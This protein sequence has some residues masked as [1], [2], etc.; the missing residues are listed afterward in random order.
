MAKG[1]KIIS[2]LLQIMALVMIM[3]SFFIVE[4]VAYASESGVSQEETVTLQVKEGDDI[5]TALQQAVKQYSKV[6]IPAG[7]YTCSGVALTGC[8]N[9][10]I[11]ATGASVT[12]TGIADAG[13]DQGRT[14]TIQR[15]NLCF[16]MVHHQ[17]YREAVFPSGGTPDCPEKS[18]CRQKNLFHLAI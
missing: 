2:R 7:K 12:A 18:F 11:E 4:H 3:G 15:L 5:T 16:F 6:V 13:K 14:A 9:I 1:K 17:K 8:E 10:T